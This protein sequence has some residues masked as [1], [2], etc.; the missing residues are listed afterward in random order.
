[1]LATRAG[2]TAKEG[3]MVTRRS[4]LIA[5][6]LAVATLWEPATAGATQKARKS[7]PETITLTVQGMT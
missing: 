6:G 4:M 3:M 5:V 2:N 7:K 1:M